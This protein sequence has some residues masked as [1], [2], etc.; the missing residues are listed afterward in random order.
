M[1]LHAITWLFFLISFSYINSYK[2]AILNTAVL[3]FYPNLKLHHIVVLKK[4]TWIEKILDKLGKNK[5]QRLLDNNNNNNNNKVLKNVYIIDYTP[6]HQPNI[7]E[8]L[9]M[10]LG[11][12]S[13]GLTR[14]IYLKKT[15]EDTIVNDWYNEIQRNPNYST[16]LNLIG[17]KKISEII[18]DW[19]KQ[20]NLY[21][22]NCQHFSYH[23]T[24][25]I[26]RL[27]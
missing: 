7:F 23:F 11:Q 12:K 19:D 15:T 21:S 17:D 2:T 22:N 20:F 16:Y 27:E 10:L 18:Y 24:N 8:Y 6:K 3:P 26:R 1:V 4:E 5:K 13:E 25:N 14:V 9:L